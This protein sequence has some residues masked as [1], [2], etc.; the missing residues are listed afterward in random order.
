MRLLIN[1]YGFIIHTYFY[2]F[3]LISY[4]YNAIIQML[5]KISQLNIATLGAFAV[6]YSAKVKRESG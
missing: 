5:I 6:L 1:K 3:T 2:K 4:F